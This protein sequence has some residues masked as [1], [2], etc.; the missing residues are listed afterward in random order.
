MTRHTTSLRVQIELTYRHNVCFNHSIAR[1]QLDIDFWTRRDNTYVSRRCNRKWATLCVTT[2][3]YSLSLY[4]LFMMAEQNFSAALSTWKGKLGR[5]HDRDK[6]T[7]RDQS[8][9]AAE[10]TRLDCS[11]AGRESERE[12]GGKEEASGTDQRSVLA[13]HIVRQADKAEFK[14]QPDDNEK[15]NSIK[16]LLKAYQ[17]EIDSLTR[18]SK[19]S[20]TS[21]LNLYKLLSDAP[22]PYP[23]LDAA[24]D[25]TV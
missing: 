15:F 2:D 11:R 4:T 3:R 7:G 19:M 6:L 22:D 21:F 23:L 17:G 25:Q 14:K 5:S 18:R 16:V 10:V 9:G 13:R 24:V 8:L 20:E 1:L 12:Y